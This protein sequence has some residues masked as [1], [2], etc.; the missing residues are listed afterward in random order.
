MREK[1]R[2][3]HTVPFSGCKGKGAVVIRQQLVQVSDV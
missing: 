2:F 1:Q 3:I